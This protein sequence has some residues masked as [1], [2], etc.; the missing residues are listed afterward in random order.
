MSEF[1]VPGYDDLHL[2]GFGTSGE[3]WRARRRA[4]G[5]VVALRRAT[6]VDRAT[7]AAAKTAAATARG[8]ATPHLIRL[9]TTARVAG[10]EVLVLDHADGG[11]LAS[12]LVHRRQ[13]SPGEVVTVVAPLAEALAQAHAVELTHGRLGVSSVLLAADGRPLLDGLGLGGLH[14]PEDRL[15][16][17]G[18]LGAAADVWALGALAHRLLTGEDPGG[19]SLGE[20]A[21]T[22]PVPLVRA[23]VA[24]LAFDPSARPTA[25]ELAAAVLAACPAL[26]LNGVL[27]VPPA[28]AGTRRWRL[29]SRSTVLVST[30]AAAV[31]VG[32]VAAGLAWGRRTGVDPVPAA[33]PAL[34]RVSSAALTRAA[35]DWRAVVEGLDALR[36]EAFATGDADLLEG[37]YLPGSAALADDRTALG[38]LIAQGATAQGLRHQMRAVAV[39][40]VRSDRVE[41]LLTESLPPYRVVGEQVQLVP[42]GGL[43]RHR[44]V[45][46]KV[47]QG[48]RI[49][50]VAAV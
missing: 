43:S 22:A 31:V 7:L 49:E 4:G 5:E 1:S 47:A 45:L 26:P 21:P 39:E 42:A 50:Q 35:P 17:T 13:L 8:L 10:E 3:V 44:M 25:A 18:A 9:R 48:W 24:A 41:L 14:D 2:L 27:A 32:V 12:V 19:T 36:A 30:G 23:V 40:A 33:A 37:V 34:S 11:S 28:P 6:G 15:D 29:P 16:P 38:R 20:L 46:I